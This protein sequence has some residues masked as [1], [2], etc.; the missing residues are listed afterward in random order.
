MAFW[1]T[2]AEEGCWWVRKCPFIL[3]HMDE[4]DSVDEK[5]WELI[6]KGPL[7]L[8]LG[9]WSLVFTGLEEGMWDRNY[10]SFCILL[11]CCDLEANP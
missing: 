7:L 9:G 4:Q 3:S 10:S 1:R 8:G 5:Y 11:F 2:K 6:R